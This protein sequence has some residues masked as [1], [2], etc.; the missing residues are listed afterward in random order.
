MKTNTA[1][2]ILSF[3]V[4]LFHSCDSQDSDA[5]KPLTDSS[6]IQ[7]SGDKNKEQTF[8]SNQYA[9]DSTVTR[10]DTLSGDASTTYPSNQYATDSDVIKK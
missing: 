8:S 4:I 6:T 3:A 7:I 1:I 9:N 5:P 2:A 10:T